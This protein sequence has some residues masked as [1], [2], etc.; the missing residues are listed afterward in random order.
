MA[1]DATLNVGHSGELS[2]DEA[3]DLLDRRARHYLHMTGR[4]FI[5][6]WDAGKFKDDA[7]RPEVMRV[8]VLIPFGR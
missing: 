6:A 4:E 3:L 7:D 2:D 5:E 1:L 8:A